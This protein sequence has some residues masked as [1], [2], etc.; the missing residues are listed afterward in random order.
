MPELA[1]GLQCAQEQ[2][3]RRQNEHKNKLCG[4]QQPKETMSWLY[5]KFRE[6]K[7]VCEVTVCHSEFLKEVS[8][9]LSWKCMH[10]FYQ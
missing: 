6:M 7:K 4:A 10:L 5:Y 9:L 2:V 3:T 1:V 8:K